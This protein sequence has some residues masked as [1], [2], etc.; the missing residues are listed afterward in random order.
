MGSFLFY[1]LPVGIRIWRKKEELEIKSAKEST[2][3]MPHAPP[4]NRI[5]HMRRIFPLTM[6]RKISWLQQK[7]VSQKEFSILSSFSPL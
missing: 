4:R 3:T 1:K 2:G 6:A 7:L 5:A